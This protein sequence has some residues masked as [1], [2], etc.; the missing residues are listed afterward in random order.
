MRGFTNRLFTFLVV[1]MILSFLLIGF[2][3]TNIVSEQIS[4]S[5]EAELKSQAEQLLEIIQQDP[6]APG[7]IVSYDQVSLKQVWIQKDEQTI[8]KSSDIDEAGIKKVLAPW[9]N[10]GE[11][12]FYRF[13]ENGSKAVLVYRQEDYTVYLVDRLTDL[14]GLIRTIWQYLTLTLVTAVPI[15][16]FIVRYIY[17]SYIGPIKEV[18]YA[19]KLLTE[20]NYKVRVPESTV[21]E[22]KDLYI[23]T[24]RLARTLQ[25]LNNEQKL[26]RNRLETT[27]GNI[28]S[29]ILMVDK[30]GQ[31]VIV[32]DTYNDTFNKGLQVLEGHY[33]DVITF[34]SINRMIKEAIYSEKP[35]NETIDIMLNVHKKYF[36]AA[37]VPVLSRRRRKLEGVVVV[38]HD[39]T[40]L[41]SLEQMRKDFVANVSH[42]LKTPITSIKGFSETLLDGAKNDPDTLDMFLEIILKESNRIQG[43]VS[44]L[45]ELSKIEQSSHILLG[46]VN[47]SQKTESCI[48]VVNQLASKKNISI[49][50]S[51]APD[52]MVMAEASKLKQVIINLLSN[53]INY[54]HEGAVIKVNV[55]DAQDGI[56]EVIDEGMGIAKEEQ[57]RIFERFY[58]VDKARSRDSGGTGLGLAIVKHIIE[59]FGG[60]IE[61]ESALG[62]GSI[63]RVCLKKC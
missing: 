28:P 36:D 56:L 58:R 40:K 29:A 7:E 42:E 44:E 4:K 63:F 52:V 49:E 38:L 62:K 24:N 12:K 39:I 45:L 20:G 43:L 54:S 11:S 33:E 8:F 53:A 5:K 59:V 6:D 10:T 48:E 47:L 30:Q 61:V 2:F 34:P 57:A 35:I 22:T 32:N 55:K 15:I 1:L 51:I 60:T 19:S 46:E 27:L 26:Q 25:K 16:F 14:R 50:T 23:S 37:V 31:V 3:L 13:Q 21:T 41:K 17:R 9:I 18:T